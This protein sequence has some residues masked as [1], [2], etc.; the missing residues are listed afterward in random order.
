[1]II[2]KFF[3]INFKF[4]FLSLILFPLLLLRAKER[5]CPFCPQQ[6]QG[7]AQNLLIAFSDYGKGRRLKDCGGKSETKFKKVK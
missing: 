6:K 1:L 4:I 3:Y 5:F 2:P 7:A